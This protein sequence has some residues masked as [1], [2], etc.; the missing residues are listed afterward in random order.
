M[1]KYFFSIP[2]IHIGELIKQAPDSTKIARIWMP[3]AKKQHPKFEPLI[4]VE[5]HTEKQIEPE[6]LHLLYNVEYTTR[7]C[8][9]IRSEKGAKYTIYKLGDIKLAAVRHK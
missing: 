8:I 5:V 2:A 6:G 1:T 4:N 3:D 7:P 9:T